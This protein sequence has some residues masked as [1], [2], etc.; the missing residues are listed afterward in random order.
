MPTTTETIHFDTRSGTANY[1]PV[2]LAYNPW[3]VRIPLMR[4]LFNVVK[5][6]LKSVEMPLT[7]LQYRMSND[8]CTCYFQFDYGTYLGVQLPIV[9]QVKNLTSVADL[10]SALNTA[11]SSALQ[12]YTN[13]SM[14]F[15]SFVSSFDGLTYLTGT[16]NCAAFKFYQY[17][18]LACDV[19]GFPVGNSPNYKPLHMNTTN[20]V[21]LTP[22][23]YFNLCVKNVD[24][25]TNANG[26]Q[27]TFK[28][29]LTV[30]PF[31]T[32]FYNETGEN[33]Q[34]LELSNPTNFTYLD[35]AIYDAWGAPVF[36]YNGHF[37]FSINI[38]SLK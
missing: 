36:G 3:N 37:S 26:I 20:P 5:M 18:V 22:D 14:V 8:S 9:V 15:S 12:P 24:K 32:L 11:F 17:S 23:I 35:V 13:V 6:K 38:E 27:G 31:Q 33:T 29:P 21:N 34:V 16:T 19:M 28:I 30:S 2:N 4:P 7:F 10:V 1:D 25:V